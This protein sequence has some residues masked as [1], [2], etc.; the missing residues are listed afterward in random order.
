MNNQEK[1]LELAKQMEELKAKMKEISPQLVEVM[2]EMGEGTSFQDPTDNVV[3]KITIP[4]GTY[5]EFKPIAYV[6]TKRADEKRGT[7]S[8]KEAQELGYDL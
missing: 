8:K 1:F 5:V 7:L 6:R 2:K 3:Y 4:T